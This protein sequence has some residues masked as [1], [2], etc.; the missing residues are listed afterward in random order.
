MLNLLEKKKICLISDSL[1]GKLRK[2][3]DKIRQLLLLE[4]FKQCVH[5]DLKKTFR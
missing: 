1:Q 3:F 5:V 2:H 4:E